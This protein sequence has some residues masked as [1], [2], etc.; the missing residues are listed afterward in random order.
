MWILVIS[1]S[2]RCSKSTIDLEWIVDDPLHASEGTNHEDSCS[3]TLPET[4]E[5]NI[6]VDFSSTLSCLVHD[7]DHCVCGMGNDSTEDTSQVTRGKSNSKLCSLSIWGFFFCKNTSVELLHNFFECDEL[8]NCVRNLSHP[9][10]FDTSVEAIETFSGIYL[11][12][13]LDCTSWER[14]NWVASLHSNFELFTL[15]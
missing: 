1:L 3:E 14:S 12:E 4:I 2:T 10:R 7:W 8:D 5:T 13:S 9:K 11:S 6:L 15:K